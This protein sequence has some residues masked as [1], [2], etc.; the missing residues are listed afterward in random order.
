MLGYSL[1]VG[2]FFI[3][4]YSGVVGQNCSKIN[5]TLYGN[6]NCRTLWQGVAQP[7]SVGISDSKIILYA[8]RDGHCVMNIHNY[9]TNCVHDKTSKTRM[10]TFFE[11][12]C[13]FNKE[14]NSCLYGY[15]ESTAFLN[16]ILVTANCDENKSCSQTDD[17]YRSLEME[18]NKTGRCIIQDA[19]AYSLINADS[20]VGCRALAEAYRNCKIKPPGECIPPNQQPY[21]VCTVK[22]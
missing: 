20:R 15:T 13:C 14:G 4:L 7:N 10:Q 18:T 6:I 9:L 1:I 22:L 16:R 19:L 17:C 2:I 5:D 21:E 8:C 11:L 12:A 3:Q